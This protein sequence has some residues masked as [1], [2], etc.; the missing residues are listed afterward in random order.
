M[1]CTMLWRRCYK[2]AS[3]KMGEMAHKWWCFIASI[4]AINSYEIDQPSKKGRIDC[5]FYLFTEPYREW[6]CFIWALEKSGKRIVACRY[7]QHLCSK[8]KKRNVSVGCLYCWNGSLKDC[9]KWL[10]DRWKDKK[11]KAI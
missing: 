8:R 1:W 11:N 7:S 9:Q 5:V 3:N 10:R 6:S 4:T 2:K